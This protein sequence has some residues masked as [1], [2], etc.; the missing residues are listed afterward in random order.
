MYYI[1][2]ID[3]TCT[4]EDL[5]QYCADSC[6]LLDCRLMPS[7]RTGTR[8]AYMYVAEDYINSMI[9]TAGLIHQLI[10]SQ[11]TS[12]KKEST[13]IGTE[14]RKKFRQRNWGSNPGPLVFRTSALTTELSRR[15][16]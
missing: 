2:G 10:H 3:P 15:S 5:L 14:E 7:R 13:D 4:A 6:P 11:H 9:L 1:G 16:R 8:S 12:R